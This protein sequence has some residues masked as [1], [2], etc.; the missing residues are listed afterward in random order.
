MS[1]VTGVACADGPGAFTGLRVGL[2]TAAGLAQALGVPLWTACSLDGRARAARGHPVPVLAM[3]DARKSRVY[4]A[5]YAGGERTVE[6]ADVCPHEALAWLG[7]PFV[8]TG[9]GALVYRDLVLASGAQLAE[10]SDDP[11]V[12]ALGIAAVGAL[13]AG[14]GF[15]PVEVR[16]RYLREPDAKPPR[17]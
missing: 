12:V 17:R 11:G 7:G 1:D 3:L 6:P 9:E 15:D 14:E 10:S 4:A 5:A 16:P 8:A 13:G 2:A